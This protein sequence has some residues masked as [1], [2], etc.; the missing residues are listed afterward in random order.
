MGRRSRE[1]RARRAAGVT[2]IARV[3]RVRNSTAL[4]DER[5][6]HVGYLVHPVGGTSWLATCSG[7]PSD[8]MIDE[9]RGVEVVRQRKNLAHAARL[10]A[11]DR[12]RRRA[13]KAA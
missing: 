2:G 6:H 5:G 3:A 9:R 1:L 4:F 12:I 11:T 13:R 10:R 7:R 8:R